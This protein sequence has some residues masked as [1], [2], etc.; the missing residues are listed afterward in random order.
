MGYSEY[1]DGNLSLEVD[2]VVREPLDGGAAHSEV[3]P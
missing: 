1:A 3:G 2:D